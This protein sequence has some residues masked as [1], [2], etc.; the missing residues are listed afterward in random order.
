MLR[1]L[2][3]EFLKLRGNRQFFLMTL[4]L[5]IS[6]I[7]VNYVLAFMLSNAPMD[8][9]TISRLLLLPEEM[10]PYL[11]VSFICGF[12]FPIPAMIII[13]HTC[14]E[15]TYRTH[16]QN[17]IDGLTRRQYITTKLSMVVAFALI[18]TLTVYIS[19]SIMGT[20][21]GAPFTFIAFKYI[22]YYFIQATMYL[23][24]AFL[25]ALLLKRAILSLGI[26]LTYVLI[27]ENILEYKLAK[28][29]D[30]AIISDL[31]PLSS[32]DHLIPAPFK[33][34]L[35]T[36]FTPKPEIVYI[37]ASFVYI[38]ACAAICFYRYEKQDL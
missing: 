23:S 12:L 10:F 7:G 31:L 11:L 16:R 36:G 15:Y 14:A 6:I 34:M 38:A 30:V 2:S 17:I 25:L 37:I 28:K 32:T 8:Q 19:A 29:F 20:F 21:S 3:I 24:L 1:L 4:I 27:F 5:G 26:F 9:R 35:M 13:M 33:D 22:F 18:T